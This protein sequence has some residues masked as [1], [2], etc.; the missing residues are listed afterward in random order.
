MIFKEKWPFSALESC[1][2]PVG[3]PKNG[4]RGPLKN[5]QESHRVHTMRWTCTNLYLKTNADVPLRRM[6]LCTIKLY[7]IS[8][9]KNHTYNTSYKQIRKWTKQA[10]SKWWIIR[11]LNNYNQTT[12]HMVGNNA[13]EF[14]VAGRII[15]ATI[16][17]TKR[18]PEMITGWNREITTKQNHYIWPWN[19]P[20]DSMNHH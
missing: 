17:W 14:I 20:L 1:V 18:N 5:F 6:Y 9:F 13:F 8:F 19:D 7:R 15:V 11:N 3:R 10:L 4:Q 12:T 2:F 16:R